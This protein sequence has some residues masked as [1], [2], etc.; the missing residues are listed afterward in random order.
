MAK[1]STSKKTGRVKKAV[2]ANGTNTPS[3]I[4][5]VI[6][7]FG[8]WF[9]NYYKDIYFPAI[10]NS[11]LVP[12]RADDL[13][14]PSNIVQDIWELTK[15]AKI[16]LADLTNKNA[17]VFYELGL[18]H[19]LAKPAILITETID[20]IPFDLR[21][22]RIIEYDKNQPDWGTVLQ[23]SLENA[24]KET[25]ESPNQTIPTAF[26]ETKRSDI[27]PIQVTKHEK[28][29]LELKQ[30]LEIIKRQV[31]RPSNLSPNRISIEPM[32]KVVR[33]LILTGHSPSKALNTLIR[34]F[35]ISPN[36][37]ERIVDGVLKERTERDEKEQ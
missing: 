13:F 27:Q 1:Q 2:T 12:R 6:M 28:D 4:C 25:L 23:E 26:L 19:A 10:E 15:K 21:S 22:L 9:D 36:L 30:E 14:R 8:G 7:P 31:A 37:A 17:N 33:E 29:L 20:D 18:A 5:F 11:G 24:I 16:I 34:E 3:D 32:R 35:A